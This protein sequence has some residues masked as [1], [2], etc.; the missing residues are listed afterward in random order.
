MKHEDKSVSGAWFKPREGYP[1][2]ASPFTKNFRVFIP[3]FS[4]VFAVE[5]G[6]IKKLVADK[7][8]GFIKRAGGTD[9]FFH[10]TGLIDV[11]FDDLKEGQAVSFEV[12]KGPKGDRAEGVR[13]VG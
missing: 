11:Q 4:E 3:P 13:V 12:G 10:T 1:K 5:R 8:Y 6:Q 9:L 2:K 7:G